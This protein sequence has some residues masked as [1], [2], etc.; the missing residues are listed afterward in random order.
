MA[1]TNAGY[2]KASNGIIE[3]GLWAALL[4]S[5]ST[6][7]SASWY[8]RVQVAESAWTVSSTGAISNS[9]VVDF[10]IATS[11]GVDVTYGAL[12]TAASGGSQLDLTPVTTNVS[13]T[14]I[15]SPVTIP[16]GGYRITPS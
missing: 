2:R 6:E 8:D 15:G 14:E 11:A 12:Y 5:S 13:P 4:T 1:L 16:A 3:G 9:G 7:V 10:G